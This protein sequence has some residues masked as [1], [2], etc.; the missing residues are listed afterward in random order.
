MNKPLVTHARSA[1]MT[2]Q[3]GEDLATEY[4]RSLGYRIDGR[5]VR[6]GRYEIDIVAYDVAEDMTVFV[7][8]KTRT[9]HSDAYPI[10]AAL[11]GRK[12]R[13]MR[14]AVKR[15]VNEHALDGAG[16]IDLVSIHDGRVLEHWKD[17]GS[18]FS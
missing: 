9:H 3:R 10:H 5:N 12:R 1:W 13:A 8:V 6:Y 11:D 2:G 14:R 16:R 7:E 17:L 15:Y 18:D 4:L